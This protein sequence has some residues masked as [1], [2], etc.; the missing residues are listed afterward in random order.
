MSPTAAL[1]RSSASRHHPPPP[2]ESPAV[3]VWGRELG[4]QALARVCRARGLEAYPSGAGLKSW[5]ARVGSKPCLSGPQFPPA[6]AAGLA[7]TPG[8]RSYLLP[9]ALSQLTGAP[10][11]VV[12]HSA[13]ASWPPSA[14]IL[15]RSRGSGSEP[16]VRCAARPLCTPAA[17][18]WSPGILTLQ[19]LPIFFPNVGLCIGVVKGGPNLRRM[20]LRAA[21]GLEP[22]GN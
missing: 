12:P 1:S 4:S 13:E 5:G 16:L 19:V 7:A 2:G 8:A 11:H 22:P 21:A 20:S 9:G 3:G 17:V 6:A 14:A 10:D 15:S 18:L